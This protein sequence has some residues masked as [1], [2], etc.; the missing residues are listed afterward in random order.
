M[1]QSIFNKIS[2]DNKGVYDKVKLMYEDLQRPAN[3]LLNYTDQQ[4]KTYKKYF[5]VIEFDS[6][7]SLN[8]IEDDVIINSTFQNIS[9]IQLD[10][11][12]K[13]S[14]ILNSYVKTGQLTEDEQASFEYESFDVN[15]YNLKNRITENIIC[16]NPDISVIK[17][18]IL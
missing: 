9:R 17:F 4:W 12:S 8:P 14:N 13:V 6:C 5:R 10:F 18:E 11:V 7:F 15:V 1:A 2:I 16:K 3:I